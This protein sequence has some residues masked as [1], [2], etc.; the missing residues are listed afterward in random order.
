MF[1]LADTAFIE[2]EQYGHC[3]VNVRIHS[4]GQKKRRSNKD[5]ME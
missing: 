1:V 5:K 4:D 3:E 2:I